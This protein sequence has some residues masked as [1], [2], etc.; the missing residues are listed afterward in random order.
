MG[1]PSKYKKAHDEDAF[2]QCLLGATDEGLA[3]FFGVGTNTVSR[4]KRDHPSFKDALDRGKDRA[5]GDVVHAMYQR[6]CGYSHPETKFLTVSLGGN[7]GSEVKQFETTKHYP[8][9]TAAGC[10]WMKNRAGW[11]DKQEVSL[12]LDQKLKDFVTWHNERAKHGKT[13]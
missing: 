8:P 11:K 1:R 2:K 5:D 13:G 7:L 6:A 12:G 9:D 3:E 10:F 4:W